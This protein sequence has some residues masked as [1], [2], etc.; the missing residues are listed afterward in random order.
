MAR[1]CVL[2]ACVTS[3]IPAAGRGEHRKLGGM[4][5]RPAQRGVGPKHFDDLGRVIL[6]PPQS[7]DEPFGLV[8]RLE[9]HFMGV[10]FQSR[11]VKSPEPDASVAPSGLKASDQ[12]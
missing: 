6:L 10:V 12:T 7:F 3:Q 4:A 11:T 9:T 2:F 1:P 8:S 5:V